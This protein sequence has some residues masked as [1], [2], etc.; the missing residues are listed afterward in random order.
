V[1]GRNHHRSFRRRPRYEA[2][3]DY[4]NE[5]SWL[6]WDRE[7]TVGRRI[8]ARCPGG[9]GDAKDV[10]RALNQADEVELHD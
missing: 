4:V 5:G 3:P 7:S 2:R 10:A 1:A 9:E 6:V 8:K